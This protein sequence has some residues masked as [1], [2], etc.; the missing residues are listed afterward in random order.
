M[1]DSYFQDGDT[2]VAIHFNTLRNISSKQ[3]AFYGRKILV[4]L[5]PISELLK[6]GKESGDGDPTTNIADKS[7]NVRD[8]VKTRKDGRINIKSGVASK[9]YETLENDPDHFHL[10]NLFSLYQNLS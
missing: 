1:K 2:P 9:I 7:A 10:L 8:A 3:D 6:L 4:G 5:A